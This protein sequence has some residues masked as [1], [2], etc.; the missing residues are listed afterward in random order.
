M[1]MMYASNNRVGF[2]KIFT[3]FLTRRRMTLKRVSMIY[4]IMK[5]V[6]SD[7]ITISCIV[8][9]VKPRLATAAVPIEL[10]SQ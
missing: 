1:C 5:K 10:S 8:A 6:E 2:A 7:V 3:A 9:I 4:I